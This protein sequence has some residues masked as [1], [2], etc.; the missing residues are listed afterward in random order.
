MGPPVNRASQQFLT[1]P[2]FSSDQNGGVGGSDL[3]YTRNQR[4]QGGRSSD[5]LFKHRG[6][7]DFFP[8]KN[9]L[10]LESLR[11]LLAILDI[12]SRSIPTRDTSLCIPKRVAPKN[13]PAIS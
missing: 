4:L 11:S 12:D 3:G 1:R 2:G 6:L 9:V 10:V 7:G 13:K 5:N 8:Q